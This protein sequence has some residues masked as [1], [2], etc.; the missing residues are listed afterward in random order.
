MSNQRSH[1]QI[2]TVIGPREN[3]ETTKASVES[4]FA[5]TTVDNLLTYGSP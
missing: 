1:C 3:I 5:M 4:N 2:R